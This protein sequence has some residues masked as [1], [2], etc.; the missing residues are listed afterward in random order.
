MNTVDLLLKLSWPIEYL[1]AGYKE[2]C[3]IKNE[4]MIKRLKKAIAENRKQQRKSYS[5]CFG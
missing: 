1:K 4:Q 5:C 3:L 2:A